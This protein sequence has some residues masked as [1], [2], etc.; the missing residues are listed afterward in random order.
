MVKMLMI[1]GF[2][3]AD[4]H[5]GNILVNTKTGNV[6][7]IDTGMVGEITVPQRLNFVQL[8]LALQNR[9]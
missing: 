6:T 3:H 4:P 7:F 2:F 1:D 8:L 5:P 9:T